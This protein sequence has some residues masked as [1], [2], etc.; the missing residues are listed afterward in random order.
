[1]T[2]REE[3]GNQTRLSACPSRFARIYVVTMRFVFVSSMNGHP[4]FVRSY[5]WRRGTQN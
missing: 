4:W 1:M 2:I 5:M 3:R